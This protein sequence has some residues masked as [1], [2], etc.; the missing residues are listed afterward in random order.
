QAHIGFLAVEQRGA[1][2]QVGRDPPAVPAAERP[3]RLLE[4][5]AHEREGDVGRAVDGRAC[6]VAILVVEIHGR[7]LVKGWRGT[8]WGRHGREPARPVE[9]ADMIFG[10]T[11]TRQEN[12]K[13]THAETLL[14]I[15]CPSPNDSPV[16]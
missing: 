2:E 12:F 7:L 3:A 1:D 4:A 6:R 13:F 8:P 5:I 9:A 14:D 15:P 10:R 16:E 11:G